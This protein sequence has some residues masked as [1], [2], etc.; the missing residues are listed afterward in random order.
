[1]TISKIELTASSPSIDPGPVTDP[2]HDCP[3]CPRLVA[4]R[5]DN[6]AR[7]PDWFNGPVP[8]FGKPEASLTIVGL[9]PGVQGANRT[10]RPFTGDYAGE[11]L[12]ATLIEYGFATGE[13]LARPDDGLQLVDCRITNAVR[14]V[15]PQNK[16]LPIEINTCRQFL[17]ATLTTMPRLRAIVA[18]GRVAHDTVLKA[19]GVKASAA[20][21]GHGAVHD[22][23]EVTLYDSYHCS[24]YNTNTGVLT[25]DMFRAV[26]ARVRA[27]L[28]A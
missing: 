13:F 17:S 19:L 16:P 11:L 22:F 21:F 10:G 4:Y 8:S 5:H 12:Y 1:M 18:L 9:A 27:D 15:P 3:L 2:G 28:S 7:E 26:F 24:R 25:T 14:C 20:K 6:R 23:G